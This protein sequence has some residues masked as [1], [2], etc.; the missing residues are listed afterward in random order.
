MSK[1]TYQEAASTT[2]PAYVSA[3]AVRGPAHWFVP[4]LLLV[5]TSD[6]ATAAGPHEQGIQ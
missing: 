1:V 4:G 6:S 2:Q 3:L 5:P